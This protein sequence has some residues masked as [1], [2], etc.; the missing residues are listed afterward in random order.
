M[1]GHFRA[2][3]FVDRI[4]LL[5]PG[6]RVRG[7]YSVPPG[8]DSFTPSLAAEAVG[9]L[10]AW[11][12]MAG[13][14]F[15]VRPVAGLAGGVEF[16]APIKPGE[17]LDLSAELE[18]VESDAIAYGG[19][20]RVNGK[21]VVRLEHCVGPMVPLEEFDD[22]QAVS[23]RFK[24]LCGAGATP[25]AFRG[26]PSMMLDRTPG[27]AGKIARATLHVPVDAEFF[28]DHF[29]RKPVFPGTL[30]MNA[31]LRLAA[32]LA[33]ELPPPATAGLRWTL[34]GVSDVKLRSFIPPGEKLELEA[35]VR[36]VNGSAATLTVD[37]RSNG[38]LAGAA[39]VQLTP[40]TRT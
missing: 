18:T 31:N 28:S 14:N 30:L 17:V 8:I 32:E 3:S 35:R 7:V 27:E 29:P 2:F 10:A 26:V 12:A 5:E 38:K 1:D 21:T 40:E 19:E 15:T 16:F 13:L 22:P 34:R 36:E 25:G 4:T 24:L 11:A 23:E 39:R 37:A 33:A 20:A 9:Q 6:V